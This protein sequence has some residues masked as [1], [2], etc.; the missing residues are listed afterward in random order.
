MSVSAICA[1]S[2]MSDPTPA[3]APTKLA[4][5]LPT[6]PTAPSAASAAS[7]ALDTGPPPKK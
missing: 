2:P 5:S 6:A 7:A 3:G 1:A 4:T